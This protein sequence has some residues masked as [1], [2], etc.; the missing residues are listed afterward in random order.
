MAAS[1]SWRI[2]AI[3]EAASGPVTPVTSDAAKIQPDAVSDASKKRVNTGREH[4]DI[5]TP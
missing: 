4:G 3:S 1:E 5:L 2:S